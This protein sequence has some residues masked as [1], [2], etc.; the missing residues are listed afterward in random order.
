MN[1]NNDNAIIELY[2]SR[3]QRAV[4]ETAKMYGSRLNSFAGK[5]INT[6][7]A[8]E[9][10]NDTYMAAWNSIPPQRPDNLLAWLYKTCRNIVCDRI[11]WNNAK[12]RKP[13]VT[14]L[15]DELSEC[16]ADTSASF[17]GEMTDLGRCL[18]DFLRGLEKEKRILF[19]RRYWYG[20][21]IEEL[22]NQTGM[23]VSNV[24]TTLYRIRKSLQDYLIQEGEMNG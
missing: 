23:S 10:V 9:C 12:K 2:F 15:L 6:E 17:E 3:D 8:L 14:V 22:S 13:E 19:L 18:S 7:D 20:L 16:I 5:M 21:S 4:E 1:Q 11:D 24:K